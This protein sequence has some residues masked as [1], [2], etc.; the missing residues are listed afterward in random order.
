[1]VSLLSKSRLKVQHHKVQD[2]PEP[3]VLAE[4]AIESPTISNIK[5]VVAVVSL[6]PRLEDV[7]KP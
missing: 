1:M 3:M 6:K 5:D 7:N 2:I 4:D